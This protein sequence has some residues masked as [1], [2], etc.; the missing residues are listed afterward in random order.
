VLG[1]RAFSSKAP[2]PAPNDDSKEDEEDDELPKSL[3][4]AKESLVSVLEAEEIPE[5]EGKDREQTCQNWLTTRKATL[6]TVQDQH[7]VTFDSETHKV[8][9]SFR[10][11]PDEY[12]DDQEPEEEEEEEEQPEE[13]EEGED[14]EAD[15]E[16]EEEEE[17][18]HGLQQV[19]TVSLSP[20]SKSNAKLRFHCHA[21]KLGELRIDTLAL[22]QKDGKFLPVESMDAKREVIWFEGLK[23]QTKDLLLDILTF[24]GVDDEAAVFVQSHVQLEGDKAAARQLKKLVKWLAL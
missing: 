10:R 4:E 3:Q 2:A 23:Q 18:E 16:G 8:E 20:L 6:S 12:E 5:F 15:R 21:T 7:V 17:Q 24:N 14:K 11:D 13:G 19:F 1:S 22:A 9:I